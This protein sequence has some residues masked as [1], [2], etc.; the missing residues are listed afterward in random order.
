MESIVVITKDFWARCAITGLK[1]MCVSLS[2]PD[3]G[4]ETVYPIGQR[5]ESTV[6]HSCCHMILCFQS[7]ILLLCPSKYFPPVKVN[8]EQ[9][10]GVK[11]L[12]A[13]G[14]IDNAGSAT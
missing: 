11:G 3:T 4:M 1:L 13:S 12:Q 10:A 5:V 9:D 6:S 8:L 14:H 2:S 7:C